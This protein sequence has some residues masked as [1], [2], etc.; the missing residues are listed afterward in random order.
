MTSSYRHVATGLD[1]ELEYKFN[2]R[3]KDTQMISRLKRF[4]I[5]MA[6]SK[7]VKF[8]SLL[9]LIRGHITDLENEGVK[10]RAYATQANYSG[11]ETIEVDRERMK[12]FPNF[13]IVKLKTTIIESDMVVGAFEVH[14]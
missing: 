13:R 4:C 14:E 7:M 8:D 12:M 9:E 3:T 11:A 6:N 2:C 1:W 10:S 5:E